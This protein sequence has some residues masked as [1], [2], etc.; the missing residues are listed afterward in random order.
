MYAEMYAHK[1]VFVK[2]AKFEYVYP[3]FKLSII[4]YYKCLKRCLTLT[5]VQQ[6]NYL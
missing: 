2:S 4:E 3:Q 6:M 5:I 1:S